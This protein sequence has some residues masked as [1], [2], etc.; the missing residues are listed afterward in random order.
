M[1]EDIIVG[2]KFGQTE[3][4]WTPKRTPKEVRNGKLGMA[5]RRQRSNQL[6]YVPNLYNQALAKAAV[7]P[8]EVQHPYRLPVTSPLSAEPQGWP[9]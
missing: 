2:Q 1:G 8:W 4:E 6:N 3:E 7:A 5:V 9:I